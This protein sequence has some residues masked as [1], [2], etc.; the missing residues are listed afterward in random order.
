MKNYTI[1]PKEIIGYKSNSKLL[2]IYTF[3]CIKST[4]NY[5]SGISKI[6]QKTLS[7]QFNIPER[8]SRDAI[9]RLEKYGLLSVERK[10]YENQNETR[11][12]ETIRKNYYHF[13]LNPK[14]YFFIYNDFLTLNLSKKVKGFLILLK[15]ICF[16]NS[17]AFTSIKPIKRSINKTEL[18]KLINMDTK[19]ISEYLNLVKGINEIAIIDA[20]IILKSNYF[21]LK[22]KENGNRL[23]NRKIEIL[24]TIHKICNYY[25]A[26]MPQISNEELN[27]ILAN[28]PLLETIVENSNNENFI[29]NNSLKYKLNERIKSLPAQLNTEYLLKILNIPKPKKKEETKYEITLD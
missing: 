14:N 13:D 17:N 19:S 5:K 26:V 9:I 8:T 25:N 27:R 3:A 24:K 1:I 28:Y 16:N 22:I 15:A 18:S 11:K 6:Y 7:K 21:P 20:T 12:S 10:T 2:D 23:E 29:K 4:M